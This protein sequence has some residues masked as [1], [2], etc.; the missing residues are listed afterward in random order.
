MITYSEMAMVQTILV[1][2]NREEI[3]RLLMREFSEESA[4]S[5][6]KLLNLTV[7]LSDA[8]IG[9]YAKGEEEARSAAHWLI[10]QRSFND[11]PDINLAVMVPV[12]K[13]MFPNGTAKNGTKGDKLYFEA[14]V[15]LLTNPK[16]FTWEKCG[17]WAE[18]FGY[19][20]YIELVLR[21]LNSN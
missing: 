1:S 3:I 21:S 10:Q 6:R 14:M 16:V 13:T 17:E 8:A 7:A 19:K 4:E 15:K 2:E 12:C 9:H 20:D 5:A 18:Q 11:D